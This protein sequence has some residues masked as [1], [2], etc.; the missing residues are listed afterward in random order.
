MEGTVDVED[1]T[2]K[3]RKLLVKAGYLDSDQG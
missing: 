2:T 1:L 3:A